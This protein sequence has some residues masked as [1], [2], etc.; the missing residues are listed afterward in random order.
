M[1]RVHVYELN[2]SWAPGFMNWTCWYVSSARCRHPAKHHRKVVCG[3]GTYSA[4]HTSCPMYAAFQPY[5]PPKP[6]STTMAYQPW[7]R[8]EEEWI[9]VLGLYH[10]VS[11]RTVQGTAVGL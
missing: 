9:R 3:L 7:H 5:A 8:R 4:R 2:V 10:L 1:R 6:A 11:T